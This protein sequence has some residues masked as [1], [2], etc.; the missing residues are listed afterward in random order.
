MKKIITILS[1]SLGLLAFAACSEKT[2]TT[3]EYPAAESLS[4][5][6]TAL[7]LDGIGA[8]ATLSATVAPTTAAVT[9]A[10]SDP[11]VATVFNGV[12]TG[13]GRGS[14]EVYAMAGDLKAYCAVTVGHEI[15]T[16][17]LVVDPSELT[18]KAGETATLTVTALPEDHTD[19]PVY[20]WSSSD[21][22][23]ATVNGGVVTGVAAGTATI[24]VV[25]GTIEATCEVTVTSD[26]PT[27]TDNPYLVNL[28]TQYFPYDWASADATQD[29]ITMEAWV[30]PSSF[31]GSND[32]IYTIVG[33]EGI[34]L[35]RFEGSQLNLVYGGTKKSNGEY[36]EKKVT[37]STNFSTG[38]WHHVAA[39]YAKG[40]DVVLYVDGEQVGK[41]TAEDHG[42]ELNGIGATWVLPFKFYVGVSSNNRYF[43]GSIADVR[44]WNKAR[45]GEEI[46]ADM[47][48]A[49]PSTSGLMAYWRFNEGS[50]NTVK[51]YSG[52][53][54]DITANAALTWIEAERPF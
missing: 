45:T 6:Q 11:T 27:P 10:S 21:E 17:S 52:N 43:K 34:F 26:A 53:G 32:N 1:V 39:T 48:K 9:W 31:E 40:G 41:N 14:C 50:G 22:T 51:D 28:T 49:A 2:E 42:I 15:P 13:R 16:S 19:E 24:K 36:N 20:A 5:N 46:K 23:V 37:Y 3:P 25:T 44:I 47:R 33:T 30:K 38:E 12:V 18:V 7:Q 8:T 29:N 4:I 35:L 54:R